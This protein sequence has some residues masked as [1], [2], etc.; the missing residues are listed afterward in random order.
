MA[1]RSTPLKGEGNEHPRKI[2][3]FEVHGCKREP[4][5]A[6]VAGTEDHHLLSH[7][8]ALIKDSAIDPDV[9]RERG[10][11]SV[12]CPEELM[13]LGFA[14]SQARAPALLIPVWGVT[15]EKVLDQVRPDAPRPGKHGKLVK[16]ESRAGGTM[17]LDCHP[18]IRSLLADPEVPLWITE[19]SARATPSS[20]RASARSPSWACGAGVGPT[21]LEARRPSPIGR[22]LP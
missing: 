6:S 14:D 16:Y 2:T 18:R 5:S 9:A 17:A 1:K 21:P 13:D 19:G 10:Y 20:P 22:T 8:K 12:T 4:L 11:R 3:A 15:G 7:H